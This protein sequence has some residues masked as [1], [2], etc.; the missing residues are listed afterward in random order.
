MLNQAKKKHSAIPFVRADV[1]HLPFRNQ[2]FD[3]TVVTF[4]LRITL[5]LNLSLTELS[6][7]LKPRGQLGVLANHKPDGL[8]GELITTIVGKMAKIDFTRDLEEQLHQSFTIIQNQLMYHNLVQL[9]VGENNKPL[10]DI[11]YP[12]PPPVP[13]SSTK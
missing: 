7:V 11:K 6:R 3:A 1:A 10:E 13:A 9:L 8:L 5:G 2:V 12:T 4:C